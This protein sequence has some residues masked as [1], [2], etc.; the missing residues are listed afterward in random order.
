MV[1]FNQPIMIVMKKAGSRQGQSAIEYLLFLAAVVTVLIV[2]LNPSGLFKT[3]FEQTINA[4]ADIL[5]N[6]AINS[7]FPP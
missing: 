3:T 1:L 7:T 4:P 5:D 6:L 2:F